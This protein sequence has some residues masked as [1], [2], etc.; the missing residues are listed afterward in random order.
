MLDVIARGLRAR[1]PAD[2]DAA[3]VQGR[4]SEGALEEWQSS[5]SSARELARVSAAGLRH[6][7]ELGGLER[8]AV[9]V[10]RAMR[11]VRVLARRARPVAS[12]P[13][14]HELDAVADLVGRFGAGCTCSPRR[15]A[16]AATRRSRAR[17]SSRWPGAPTPT[18]SA[19]ATGRC[20]RS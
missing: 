13:D 10:D 20:S 5:A 7:D 18:C 14:D 2:L 1:D 16:R 6:R 12:S 11:S 15:S 3:L 9:L 8:Q 4:A 17:S 19:T